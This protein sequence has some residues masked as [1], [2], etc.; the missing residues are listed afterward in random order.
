[1]AKVTSK[2]QVTVP[3]AIATRYQISPGDDIEWVPAGDVIRVHKKGALTRRDDAA[4]RLELFDRA[5]DRQSQR[6][7]HGKPIA[8]T[9]DRGWKR[10]D[11]YD[12][13][14]PG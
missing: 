12:R 4:L 8:G 6:Q 3:K 1:M 11:L 7:L 10:E 2:L 14:G 5:T 9:G 13:G